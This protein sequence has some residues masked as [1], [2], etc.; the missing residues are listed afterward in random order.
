PRTPPLSLPSHRSHAPSSHPVSL[1]EEMPSSAQAQISPPVVAVDLDEVY[2]PDR[3]DW[4][5]ASHPPAWLTRMREATQHT[6]THSPPHRELREVERTI[7]QT[8]K[9]TQPPKKLFSPRWRQALRNANPSWRYRLWTDADNRALVASNYPWFLRVYDSYSTPIQA[10]L[11]FQSYGIV[12]TA[13]H[14]SSCASALMP[15]GTS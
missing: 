11:A 7:H 12:V 8:W 6:S 15:R 1:D 9:D 14:T 4:W 2:S 3:S 5:H 13:A 10:S